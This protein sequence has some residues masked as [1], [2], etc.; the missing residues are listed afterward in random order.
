MIDINDSESSQDPDRLSF[1]KPKR[2]RTR[3][4]TSDTYKIKPLAT[5]LTGRKSEKHDDNSDY[6][7][8]NKKFSASPNRK[9]RKLSKDQRTKTV[10]TITK[11]LEENEKEEEWN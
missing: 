1:K 11:K 8:I 6:L 3:K 4:F 5:A 10:I 2:T 7:N 9:K